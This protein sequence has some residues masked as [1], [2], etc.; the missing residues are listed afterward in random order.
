[1]IISRKNIFR[2]VL[3]ISLTIVTLVYGVTYLMGIEDANI[4]SKEINIDKYVRDINTLIIT[5]NNNQICDSLTGVCTPPP[6][7]YS[8]NN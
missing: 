7:W 5:E 4:Y 8:T 6:G 2:T 1:M 3:L